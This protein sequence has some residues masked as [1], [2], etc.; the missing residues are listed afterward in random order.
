MKDMGQFL[1]RNLECLTLRKVLGHLWVLWIL[2]LWAPVY[3]QHF[4]PFPQR[5]PYRQET[6]QSIAVVVAFAGTFVAGT[7]VV[8]AGIAG[9]TV[10]VAVLLEMS[11][12]AI[13]ELT[14]DLCSEIVGRSD[15]AVAEMMTWV[16]LSS[17]AVPA[18][19][20]GGSV[21]FQGHLADLPAALAV[22]AFAG[23]Q[24]VSAVALLARMLQ[25]LV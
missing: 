2:Y 24:T 21:G 14:L 19:L 13:A 11:A 10:V 8:F 22:A 5:C 20:T 25:T 15:V 3:Q 18:L 12:V 6:E 9:G 23:F 16:V 17:V 7:V 4:L 1:Q